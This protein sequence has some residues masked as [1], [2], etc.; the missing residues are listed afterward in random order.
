MTR[1]LILISVLAIYIVAAHPSR[2]QA[3]LVVNDPVNTLQNIAVLG[4]AV[5]IYQE[6]QKLR[7]IWEQFRQGIDAARRAAWVIDKT[8]WRTHGDVDDP[9]GTY[10]PLGQAFDLGDPDNRAYLASIIPLDRYSDTVL[11]SLPAALRE[12]IGRDYGNVL[13]ADGFG[14]VAVQTT[15]NARGNSRR[16][17]DALDSLQADF[18]Q[19]GD[20]Y[21]GNVGLLQKTLGARLLSVRTTDVGNQL[22]ASLL[23]G[24][25]TKQKMVR[26]AEARQINT[27]ITRRVLGPSLSRDT[28]AEM[29]QVVANFWNRV[30]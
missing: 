10:G 16:A 2:A 7:T 23:E 26:D 21:N 29:D 11:A 17:L 28:T 8:R 27:D 18:L 13:M 12:S 19:S 15:S 24:T 1:R 25:L 30:R 6:A 9:F 22:L 4:E 3:Q 14:R 5:K 20:E